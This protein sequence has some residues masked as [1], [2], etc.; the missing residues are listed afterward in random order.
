MLSAGFGRRNYDL[1]VTIGY[2]VIRPECKWL[3][4]NFWKS[5]QINCHI[6]LMKVIVY[7]I[8]TK[9][10]SIVVIFVLRNI[11]GVMED[12]LVDVLNNSIDVIHLPAVAV[13]NIPF[14][15]VGDEHERVYV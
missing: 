4:Q 3:M 6:W 8:E 9:I 7:M 15:Q 12:N 14:I 13:V 5:G 1:E 10:L 11:I 2:P